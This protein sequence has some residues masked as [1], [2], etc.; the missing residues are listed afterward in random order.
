MP[1]PVIDDL[2][3]FFAARIAKRA[4]ESRVP[5]LRR[6]GKIDSSR[7]QLQG[8]ID[9]LRQLK[10]DGAS[11]HLKMLEEVANWLAVMADAEK[12]KLPPK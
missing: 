9:K 11:K 6:I 3:A 8:M 5:Q 7:H 4:N 1:N 12:E 2:H 10:L